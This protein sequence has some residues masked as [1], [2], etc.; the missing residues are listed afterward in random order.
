[1]RQNDRYTGKIRKKCG[2]VAK[3]CL[4][5]ISCSQFTFVTNS[6]ILHTFIELSDNVLFKRTIFYINRDTYLHLVRY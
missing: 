1:M 5:K 4:F 3:F 2:S 6:Y